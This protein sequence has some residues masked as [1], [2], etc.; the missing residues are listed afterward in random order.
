MKQLMPFCCGGG[1]VYRAQVVGYFQGGGASARSEIV[2]DNTGAVPR[3]LF[4]RDLSHLGRGY[5]LETL[6]VDLTGR[7]Y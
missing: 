7:M 4:W 1:D 5:N 2:W 6:G 3:V